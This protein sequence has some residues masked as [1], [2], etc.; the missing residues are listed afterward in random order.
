MTWHGSHLHTLT[1]LA[2]DTGGSPGEVNVKQA[3]DPRPAKGAEVA[4]DLPGETDNVMIDQ[5][6]RKIVLTAQAACGT[7]IILGADGFRKRGQ[8]LI[9]V[10]EELVIQGMD[11]LHG[12]A[13]HDDDARIRVEGFYFYGGPLGEKIPDRGFAGATL[14]V[15]G[16]EFG[17]EGRGIA[18][19]KL[20]SETEVR[21]EE[22]HLLPGHENIG[23]NRQVMVH[24]SGAA[25]GRTHYKEVRLSIH[26]NCLPRLGGRTFFL[27]LQ[28]RKI[29][30]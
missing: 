16:I 27:L 19:I 9:A 18:T 10:E 15:G 12:I 24:R 23:M 22:M 30:D 29:R 11:H 1:R 14:A 5:S 7:A 2:Q 21:A 8:M 3:A 26:N 28:S 20:R 4:L 13:E 17:E 25:F 6:L